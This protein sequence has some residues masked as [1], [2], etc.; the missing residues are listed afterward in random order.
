MARIFIADDHT[1]FRKGLKLLLSESSDLTIAG[2]TGDGDEVIK[3][4]MDSG[5]DMVLLDISLPNKNGL[6]ILKQIKSMKPQ[7]HVLILSMHPEEHYAVR[8]LKSGASG[9]VTKESAPEELVKAI[10]KVSMGG[11]YISA[12]LAEKLAFD[13]DGTTSAKAPHELLSDREFQVMSMIASGKKTKEIANMLSLNEKTIS[14]YRARILQ[15]MN[16]KSNADII[17]YVLK[18]G[19]A[20]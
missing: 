18:E 3:K 10:R 11:K 15:K 4:V 8:A 20:K 14:T 9:Y 16:M 2:E 1:L 7:L 6:D 19:L 12:A 13:L 17:Q 5:C